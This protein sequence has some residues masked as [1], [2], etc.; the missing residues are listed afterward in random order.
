M[1]AT[2]EIVT[3]IDERIAEIR[4]DIERIEAARAVLSGVNET[5]KPKRRGRPPGRPKKTE[6]PP[7]PIAA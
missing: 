7:E 3:K 5:P 2:Q 1:A 6:A 4:S